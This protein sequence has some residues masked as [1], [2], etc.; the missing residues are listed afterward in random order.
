MLQKY[1]IQK[2]RLI[3]DNHFVQISRII[4][5]H[6]SFDKAAA[7]EQLEILFQAGRCTARHRCTP[8]GRCLPNMK[9]VPHKVHKF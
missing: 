4:A 8:P 1:T 6:S 7:S 3:Q 2:C 9:A 5:S